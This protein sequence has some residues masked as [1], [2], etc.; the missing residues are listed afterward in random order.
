[1]D[2]NMDRN[3]RRMFRLVQCL[4][5]KEAAITADLLGLHDL[6]EVSKALLQEELEDLQER[7]RA[8]MKELEEATKP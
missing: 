7:I 4:L 2:I 6:S 1:M 5:Q 3:A 8:I